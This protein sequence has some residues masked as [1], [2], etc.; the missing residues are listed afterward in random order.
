MMASVAV[1]QLPIRK[2][3]SRRKLSQAGN[4]ASV[5]SSFTVPQTFYELFTYNTSQTLPV[6]AKFLKILV[7]AATPSN[8]GMGVYDL[9]LPAQIL[10]D[11]P[12][13]YLYKSSCRRR[14]LPNQ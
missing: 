10:S 5:P 9:L 6:T 4:L 12:K 8:K 14:Q 7:R 11:A 3:L 2:I 13:Q 1:F